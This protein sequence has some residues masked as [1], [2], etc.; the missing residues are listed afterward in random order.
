MKPMYN[1]NK[2]HQRAE[3]LLMWQI[4][5]VHMTKSEGIT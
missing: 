4:T 1:K 3:N 5:H 2:T